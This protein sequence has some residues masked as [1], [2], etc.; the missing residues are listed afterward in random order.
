[1][2]TSE[3]REAYLSFFENKGHRRIPA[4]SLIPRNDPTL[5]FT[6][7]GMVQFKDPL[8]GKEDPGYKRATSA[9]SCV[10]AGGKHNDLENVGYTARHHTFFEMMG[11]FS[12]GDYFKEETIS[13]AWE[14]IQKEMGLPEEKLWITV[15]PDDDDSRK[16]WRNKIGI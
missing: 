4:S 11:N 8:L 3:L 7:S 5:L 14:F 13:W 2:K 1:M 6:N 12:F 10:R 16:I 9:Q 15:H